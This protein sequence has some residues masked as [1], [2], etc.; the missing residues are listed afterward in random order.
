[1][2]LD[3]VDIKKMLIGKSV[4]KSQRI[5]KKIAKLFYK[6]K[7]SDGSHTFDELYFHR[8]ILFATICNQNKDIAWKSPLH[9]DGTMFDGYFI[10]GID[11]PEGSYTYHYEDAMWKY[12]DVKEVD[13]APKWDGHEPKDVIRLLSL[14]SH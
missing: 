6:G 12:F 11:T 7:I 2:A 14:L 9:D 3:G 8:A 10:A 4:D 5:N 1:M 13:R